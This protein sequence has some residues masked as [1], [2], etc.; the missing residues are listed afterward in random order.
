MVEY[1]KYDYEHEDTYGGLYEVTKSCK[2][3]EDGIEK[4]LSE[5]Q[6]PKKG[7]VGVFSIGAISKKAR[8]YTGE[9]MEN[10]GDKIVVINAV[11]GFK[12]SFTKCDFI[13]REVSFK[14]L[15]I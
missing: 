5:V 4:S 8:E 9:V 10:Y 7:E 14:K 3:I 13:T 11:L 2:Y 12:E 6:L 15:N 1:T